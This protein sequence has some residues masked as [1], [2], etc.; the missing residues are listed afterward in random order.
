MESVNIET[1][2]HMNESEGHGSLK[3]PKPL[4]LATCETGNESSVDTLLSMG[5][6][7]A[8]LFSK[9]GITT[10]AEPL[11]FHVRLTLNRFF[12]N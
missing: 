11:F 12:D 10:D 3:A 6:S 1:K 2:D 9:T 8:T 5:A 7:T 4:L